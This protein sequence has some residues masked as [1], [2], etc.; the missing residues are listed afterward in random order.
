MKTQK[1]L[2]N[3]GLNLLLN[4][5]YKKAEEFLLKALF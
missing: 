5:E 1:E 3:E 2:W 4:R